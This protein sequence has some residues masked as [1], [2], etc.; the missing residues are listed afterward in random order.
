MTWKT[1]NETVA[2]DRN[3]TSAADTNLRNTEIKVLHEA[4]IRFESA[5][6]SLK[7]LGNLC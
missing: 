6:P 3:Q 4:S 2:R 5:L 1:M 7:A